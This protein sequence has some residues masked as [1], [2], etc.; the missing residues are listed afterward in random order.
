MGFLTEL[1]LFFVA[2][3]AVYTLLHDFLG[4]DLIN[5]AIFERFVIPSF[6]AFLFLGFVGC[7]LWVYSVIIRP[8]SKKFRKVIQI[9]AIFIALGVFFTA[10]PI[11]QTT[12]INLIIGKIFLLIG[13]M[14]GYKGLKR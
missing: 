12:T 10:I 11:N 1:S 7:A 13:F 8:P 3:T 5:N 9:A 4:L 14:L 6:V 2:L